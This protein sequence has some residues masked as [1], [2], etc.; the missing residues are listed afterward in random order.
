[1]LHKSS[2]WPLALLYAALIVFASLFPFEGWRAQGLSW[3]AI[4][5]QPLPPQYWTGFDVGSNLAG[6]VPL[7]FLLGLGM[8]RSGAARWAVWVAWGV[9]TVLSMGMEGLQ[10]Y[11]PRRV[12]S[13][14]DLLLNSL[15]AL[16]GGCLAWWLY[17]LGGVQRWASFR[18]RWLGEPAPFGLALVLLWPWALLFPAAVPLG[19]GQV[20]QHAEALLTRWLTGSPF[21]VWLPLR[22]EPLLPLTPLAFL[23][24][25]ALGVLVPCLLG[26]VLVRPLWRRMVLVGV[27]ALAGV[28]VTTLSCALGYG[29]AHAWA[30]VSPTAAWGIALGV[31]LALLAA[32]LPWRYCAVALLLGL[33]LQLNWLNQAPPSAY[34]AQT[35]QLWEQGRFVQFY[36]LG[37]WLGWLWPYAV[38]VYV[39]GRLARRQRDFQSP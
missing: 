12:P 35:L 23:L 38:L 16:L 3:W 36:G 28:G 7:G 6:Y 24:C 2:A 29:P 15:G 13:N 11:L 17:R 19:L 33:M 1:M 4:L 34:F 14:L 26:H 20:L 21:I 31:V 18:Q 32:F 25:V 22:A 5:T 27:L 10:L 9:G 37:Q 39:A 30:W 8:V